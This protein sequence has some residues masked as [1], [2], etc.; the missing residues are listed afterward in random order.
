MIYLLT[1]IC[2]Q[3]CSPFYYLNSLTYLPFNCFSNC[4]IIFYEDIVDTEMRFID[5][6]MIVFQIVLL[7]M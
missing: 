2:P 1:F 6:Y 7:K 3:V 5:K 4:V